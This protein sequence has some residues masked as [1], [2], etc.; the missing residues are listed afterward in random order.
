MLH[1]HEVYGMYLYLWLVV[2]VWLVLLDGI[3]VFFENRNEFR[4]FL[5]LSL[6]SLSL[7]F[8]IVIGIHVWFFNC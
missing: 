5:T 2:L 6:L 4:L 7:K 3:S 8:D 1:C